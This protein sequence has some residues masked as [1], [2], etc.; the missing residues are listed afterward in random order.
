MEAKIDLKRV[1]VP[2]GFLL[3]LAPFL[4]GFHQASLLFWLSIV[5][6][7]GIGVLSWFQQYIWAA[8]VGL[9]VFVMPWIFG[10]SATTAGIWYVVIGEAT[11]L[12]AGNTATVKLAGSKGLLANDDE[13]RKGTNEGSVGERSR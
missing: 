8:V 12:I 7:V 6:G 10:F 5:S 4:F 2:L 3:V 11:L 13:T 1:M 9:L